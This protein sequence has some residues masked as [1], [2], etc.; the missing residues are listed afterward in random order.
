MK[1]LKKK[2]KVWLSVSI[3]LMLLSGIVV[4]LL[5]TDF[6]NVAMKELN[7]ETEDGYVMSAYLFV[8]NNATEEKPAPAIV[9]SH[10]FANDKDMQDANFVELTRRGYVVLAIDQPSHG[11]SEIIRSGYTLITADA[12]GVYEGARYLS[13]LPYVDAEKIGIT[14]HS[15]GGNSCNMA[16][17]AD[18]ENEKRLI[19]AVLF[20]SCDAYYL[21]DDGEY[22]NIFGSRDVGMVSGQYDEFFYSTVDENGNSLPSPYFMDSANAQSFLY[23][24][25]DAAGMEP[26]AADTIYHE[27]IDGE[28]AIR[29]IYRPAVI[30]AWSHFSARSTAAVIDFFDNAF[31]APNSIA[32]NDQ[33]WQV[34]EAVNLIGTIVFVI[35]VLNLTVVLLYTPEFAELKADTLAKPLPADKRGKGWFWGSLAVT[36]LFGIV[37]YVPLVTWGLNQTVRQMQTFALGLWSMLCGIFT[38]VTMAISYRIYGKK[39]GF[40]LEERGVVLPVKKLLKTILLALIVVAISYICV[41]AMDYFFKAD[42]RF[43]T[44]AIKSFNADK[45]SY[46]FPAVLMFLVYFVANSVS[47]NSFNYNT[48][49]EKHPCVNQLVV[50]VFAALPALILP[51]VQYIK[52]Y[53]T[54]HMMWPAGAFAVL[55]LFPLVLILFTTTYTSR[56]IYKITKNPYLAG[57]INGV[58]VTVMTVANTFTTI[59]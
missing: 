18:N 45:I 4:S 33:I 52:Y 21:N 47:A 19:S 22:A 28:D 55:W 34:K 49:A 20:N 50:S 2:A 42:F 59:V 26:R 24:G 35:F 5:Q 3:V 43:W 57:I 39:N 23:F 7:I 13:G 36:A 44:L 48:I 53:S 58:I 40:D 32:P 38:I 29:V 41:F 31:G 6:G 27:T 14:G 11:D 17:V 25:I 46:M 51:W 37:T 8:P 10:G 16:V 15:M 12:T 56:Y 1:N 54:N 30:H 9:V